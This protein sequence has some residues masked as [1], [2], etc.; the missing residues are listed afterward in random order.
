[1]V[2]KILTINDNTS[3]LRLFYFFQI[4]SFCLIIG[5]SAFRGDYVSIFFV[6]FVLIIVVQVGYAWIIMLCKLFKI[7]LNINTFLFS[8]IFGYIYI[9]F[10]SK[11]FNGNINLIILSISPMFFY[12]TI[13]FYKKFSSGLHVFNNRHK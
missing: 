11:I 4:I 8:I 12:S 6:F 5:L 2:Q 1:M 13:L 10:S 3:K 9:S 7:K